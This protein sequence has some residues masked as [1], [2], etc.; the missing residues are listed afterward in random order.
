LL[1]QNDSKPAKKQ[2]LMN[3]LR[4]TL[5]ITSLF[6][7]FFPS[8]AEKVNI[9]PQTLNI[10]N[11]NTLKKILLRTSSESLTDDFFGKAQQSREFD[12]NPRLKTLTTNN[13]G[14][15]LLLDFFADKQYQAIIQNVTRSYDGITGITAK[16]AD[17][18]F[19]YCYISISDEGIAISA[20]L[21]QMDEQFMVSKRNGKNYL[22]HYKMSELKKNELKCSGIEPPTP[23]RANLR[24][25]QMENE[26]LETTATNCSSTAES[27]TMVTIDVL[28]LYTQKAKTWAETRGGIEH[29][30]NQAIQR[31]NEVMD[32]S[33]TY[34]KFE[35]VYKYQTTYT[36]TD[37]IADLYRLQD[38]EDGYMDEVHALRKQ[39]HAD[40][41][42]LFSEIEK[43]GGLGFVLDTESGIHSYAF[44]Y[45]RIQ[46]V[47]TGYTMVHEMGHNMGCQHHKLQGG[48][49][50]LYTYSYGWR[51]T[52]N[53]GKVS[54]VMTYENF[55]QAQNGVFPNIPY[56]SSP[57]LTINGTAIGNKDTANN[58]LTLRRSK[59]ITSH[60]SD[61]IN[62]SLNSLSL[63]TGTLSPTFDP[64]ILNY[65]VIVG[66]EVESI[67]VTGTPNYDCATLTGNVT[68]KSLV[69][70]IN[71][72]KIWVTSHENSIQKE[73][74]LTINR[75]PSACASYESRPF[76]TGDVSALAGNDAL[77]LN[78]EA[79]GTYLTH[80]SFTIPSS[81]QT[82]AEVYIYNQTSTGCHKLGPLALHWGPMTKIRVTKTGNYTFSFTGDYAVITLYNSNVESC[83]SFLKSN[84]FWGGSGSN[85]SYYTAVSVQL[86]ADTDY[87]LKCFRY[88]TGT[89][90]NIKI[91][92]PAGGN[93]YSETAVP[94]GMSYSYIA[95]NQQDNKIKAVSATAD[96]RT[97]TAGIYTIQGVPYTTGIDPASFIG[98][99]L[100]E[101]QTS[102]CVIP[103]M[104][105]VSMTVLQPTGIRKPADEST[106]SSTIAIYATS[107][108]I[109]IV[110]P[111]P[112][113]QVSVYSTQGIL[114]RK[115]TETNIKDIATGIYIVKAITAKDV[116]T[117]KII[118]K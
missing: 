48:S 5:L 84:A 62:T 76:F 100:D 26:F 66:N 94:V 51:G 3:K 63:S 31:S 67:S 15:I 73:Y 35:L 23:P 85:I 32:N 38:P 69:V 56:F 103:S 116:K 36:E 10:N 88:N 11:E 118:V 7:F 13:K 43:D 105:S 24:S 21:P 20:D 90:W 46:Q 9:E 113:S 19:G 52:N 77:N 109:H 18:D 114:V 34:I 47:T 110:S 104:T 14:D 101:I 8:Q 117:A 111:D 60:Y 6:L 115:T 99:T 42:M 112:V 33:K 81:Q 79:T 37:S 16:I 97:L 2:L 102:Y 74:T 89:T 83:E 29:V 30:I 44:A 49:Q 12:Y 91:T 59:N 87:Y 58:A 50:G 96:F 78:K 17:T 64:N 106:T 68:N 61:I 45:S 98:K 80:D 39:Y 27:T 75:L 40:L 4:F 71:T 55:D 57:D 93:V 53:T 108:E 72:V 86:N 92:P 95:I 54:T 107:Q 70:G 65:T 25:A 41:V 1:L 28:V 22:S 82:N